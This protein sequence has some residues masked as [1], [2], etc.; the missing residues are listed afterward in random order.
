MELLERDDEREA[1][2]TA[3]E[4][5]RSAGRVVV[6]AGE[7]GI[8]KTAL[9]SALADRH[10]VLWGACDPLITPR[11][12]GPLRDVARQAGG[13]LAEAVEG[14]REDLLSAVLDELRAPAALVIEDLHWADDATLDFVALLGR[15]LPRSRGCLVVTC[16]PDARDEVRRVLAALPR[17]CVRTVEP[18]AL[19]EEA[20]AL[21]ARRAGRDAADLH[22][23]SGGNPFFVTEVLAAPAGDGVPA[24]VR[25]AVALRAAAAGEEANAVAELAAVFPGPAELALVTALADADA[26]AVDRCVEAGLLYLRGDALAFRHDLARRAVEDALS[27][28]RRRELNAQVLA[29]LEAAGEPDTARLVHHARHAGD[30]AAIRRLAPAAARAAAAAGGHRQALEHWEAALAA[31]GPD[32]QEALEG[33][34]VEAMY[35]ARTERALEARRALLALHGAAG[36]GLRAGD[37]ERWLGRILWWSGDVA[38]ATEATDRAIE[39]LEAFPDSRE[40]AMALSARSQLSML[41]Q[42]HQEALELGTRAER[43][44]LAIGDRETLTHAKTNV[45]TTLLQQSDDRG[46]ALLEEAYALAMEDGHDDHAARA[47]VNLATAMVTRRRSDPRIPEQVERALGFV[48]ERELDGYVQYLLGV[49]AH[50]RFFRGDWDRAEADANASMAFGEDRGVSLCPA[51]IVLGRLRARRGDPS[52]GETL[53]DAWRRAVATGELQRLGPAAAAR[54]EHAW[55]EG[56]LVAVAEIA[57]PA[58]ELASERGDS[59]ARAELAY[60]LWRAGSPVPPA[61]DDPEP[62]ALAMAGD[63]AGAAA[64]WERIGFPYDQAEALS[65]AGDEAARLDALTRYEALGAPRSAAHLRRRLRADG[66]KRIPRGPRAASRLGP[67][68]LTPRETEVLELIVRGA[69]NAEIARELVISAKTVDHHVSAVLGKLGVGSR[70]E[71]GAAFDR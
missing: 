2:E 1:L 67:A 46:V 33:V 48:R 18:G 44:A 37:D 32:D 56:D 20:V 71:A 51:L 19:S 60:W 50:L 10:R 53:A 11:P 7:A 31:A 6:L 41:A 62:Y 24:S 25:D 42:R 16:R 27:P 3:I 23:T 9:V 59:W 15:R 39:R 21:L 35:C 55:L 57:R 36:D 54:A 17:E 49:R 66:V 4:E 28:L 61:E 68:G 40:L 34:A 58:Y 63:W 5:S 45:G 12:M 52:A 65:D 29:A 30:A 69:T 38:A 47:L 43:L 26:G 8:G 64:A 13:A 70:R 22:A 14:S